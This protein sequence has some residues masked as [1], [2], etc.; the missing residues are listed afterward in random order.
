MF[1]QPSDPC[2]I[3]DRCGRVFSDDSHVENHVE[4]DDERACDLWQATAKAFAGERGRN[5]PMMTTDLRTNRT[6]L[7]SGSIYSSRNQ[8]HQ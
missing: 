8:P 4:D 3:E 2:A 1:Q 6:R 7:M 5:E